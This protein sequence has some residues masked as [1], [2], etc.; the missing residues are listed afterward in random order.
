[1]NRNELEYLHYIL[2]IETVPLVREHGLLSHR[3]AKKIPHTSIAMPEIQ[4]IRKTVVVPN[5]RPLHEYVNL[6]F[7]PRNKMM[8]KVRFGFGVEHKTL[9]VLQVD[10]SVLDLPGVI[11]TD[12]NASSKYCRFFPSPSGLV[13]IDKDFIFANSWKHPDDQILE[14]RHGSAVCAEVLVPDRIDWDRVKGAYVSCEEAETKLR[15]VTPDLPITIE[16]VRFFA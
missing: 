2:P 11:I 8:S 6:Y 10:P 4:D 14:W 7:N 5:A 9:C 3:R 15:Q 16:P 12:Q 1:M 13:V